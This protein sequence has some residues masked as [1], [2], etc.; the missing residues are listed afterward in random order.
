LTL[1]DKDGAVVDHQVTWMQ[2]DCKWHE[3]LHLEPTRL[4]LSVKSH[5]QDAHESTYQVVVENISS[6]P[7]VNA[8]LSILAGDRGAEVL[9]CFWSDNSTNLLPG[10]TRELTVTF[11]TELLNGKQPHLIVEGWNI[12]PSE[13]S[14]VDGKPVDIGLHI[15]KVAKA[16]QNGEGMVKVIAESSDQ[17]PQ[18]ARLVSWPLVLHL[19]GKPV[20]TFR[21]A[22]PGQGQ[23]DAMVPVMWNTSDDVF[24][25][26]FN[27][28]A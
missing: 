13:I 21:L 1:R 25:V 9:P 20:R 12:Q 19:N 26:E 14:L 16:S 17:N 8:A 2:R 5:T 7:A 3:L 10:E 4:A 28:K 6:V 22:V 18:T 24:T 11:R 23:A 15:V 27:S